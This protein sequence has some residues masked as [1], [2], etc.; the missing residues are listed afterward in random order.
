MAY[1]KYIKKEDD[2][3][4][5][6]MRNKKLKEG[7]HYDV[8]NINQFEY[9]SD[10]KNQYIV[11]NYFEILTN[12]FSNLIWSEDPAISFAD[13][14]TQEYIEENII[15]QG[16]LLQM[17]QGSDTA[18]F[19][20]DAIF[21]VHIDEVEEGVFAPVISLV[22]NKMWYPIYDENNTNRKPKGHILYHERK[23]GE[24]E[25]DKKKAMLLEIHTAGKIEWEA[26]LDEGI[27]GQDP[28]QISPMR[29]FADV[30]ETVLVDELETR[31]GNFVYYTGC[32]Y[33]LVFQM[34]NVKQAGSIFGVSDYT[35]PVI[36][37][38]YA[39]NQNYNQI[40]YVLRKHAHPKMIVPKDV[41]KQAIASVTNND[42]EAQR[43]GWENAENANKL[44]KGDKTI[45]E[46][47]IAQKIID[48]VDFYGT[49]INSSDPKYLTWDGNLN[50]SREQINNLKKALF[51]E[52]QLA[53]VLI[54]PDI[55]T[56]NLSGVAIQR[57][58]QP[59]LHKAIA[60]KA[61]IKETISNIL[62]TVLELAKKSNLA[63]T[64]DLD[65]SYPTVKFRDG[66]VNDLKESIEA[67]QMM[68]D[69]QLTTK[70][71]AIMAIQDMNHEEAEDKYQEI[72]KENSLFSDDGIIDVEPTNND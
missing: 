65:V 52:T 16:F 4:N 46:T 18:S 33:P 56:G 26:Y 69:S 11:Y 28:K 62:Y 2:R 53:K 50:E 58:A 17:R 25:K 20:G 12:T 14:T 34:S 72:Q 49:D 40:Q 44:Y 45:F 22:D 63:D 5:S 57:L 54:D 43:M 32:K 7:L 61:Y 47:L 1:L 29:Y 3:I 6:Y 8:F 10:P 21:Q 68:L 66:L 59:S 70:I 39:I 64:A 36:A 24:D 55:A 30:M 31:N 41:I 35:V 48:K 42:E 27:F 37:K 67:Q 38:A 51:D 15:N 19:A 23:I 13:D 9:Y 71:D 60:K